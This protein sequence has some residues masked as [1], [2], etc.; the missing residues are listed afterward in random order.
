MILLV[1]IDSR[2][3]RHKAKQIIINSILEQSA[4]LTKLTLGATLVEKNQSRQTR[5][6]KRCLS[7]L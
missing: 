2:K 4:T 3:L 5:V 7:W 6:P 1:K